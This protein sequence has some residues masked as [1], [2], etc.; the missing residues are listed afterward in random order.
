MPRY[1]FPPMYKR[2]TL[3][4]QTFLHTLSPGSRIFLPARSSRQSRIVTTRE[5]RRGEVA[6]TRK[7]IPIQSQCNVSE[8]S[9]RDMGGEFRGGGPLMGGEIDLL[10]GFWCLCENGR[11]QRRGEEE[12]RGDEMK[13]SRTAWGMR[14]TR[15]G[16]EEATPPGGR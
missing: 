13:R 14:P 3:L 7:T 1:C 6:V 10:W 8:S 4:V 5:L 12:K 16:L 11:E 9:K 15:A 2:T